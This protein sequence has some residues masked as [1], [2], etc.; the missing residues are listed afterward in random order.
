[1]TPAPCSARSTCR[2]GRLVVDAK[3]PVADQSAYTVIVAAQ[4]NLY[5]GPNLVLNANYAATSVPVPKGVGPVGGRLLLT[6]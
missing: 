4:I 5:E 3:K 1:M 6:Q 2:P